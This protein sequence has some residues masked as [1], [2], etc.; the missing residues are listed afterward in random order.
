MAPV[1]ASPPRLRGRISYRRRAR[2]GVAAGEEGSSGVSVWAAPLRVEPPEVVSA[3]PGPPAP[4]RSLPR[5]GAAPAPAPPRRVRPRVEGAAGPPS[6]PRESLTARGH[7]TGCCCKQLPSARRWPMAVSSVFSHSSG[8]CRA[9]S[10]TAVSQKQ[11]LSKQ[12]PAE[13]PCLLL[14]L[15]TPPHHPASPVSFW[16][17]GVSLCFLNLNKWQVRLPN[18]WLRQL[19]CERCKTMSVT[20]KFCFVNCKKK[21]YNRYTSNLH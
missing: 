2:L 1:A 15:P 18:V 5:R 8:I 21:K 3:V 12:P 6:R 4:L 11:Q 9:R 19:T 17:S 10:A 20:N 14:S 16:S 13:T 7:G